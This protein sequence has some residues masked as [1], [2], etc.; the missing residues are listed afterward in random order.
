MHEEKPKVASGGQEI[1]QVPVCQVSPASFS[2]GYILPAA[3]QAQEV[4]PKMNDTSHFG[5]DLM[6][7]FPYLA[8]HGY[9]YQS[10]GVGKVSVLIF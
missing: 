6:L 3:K 7:L 8:I 4:E 5:Q 1:L 2:P 10:S 9:A